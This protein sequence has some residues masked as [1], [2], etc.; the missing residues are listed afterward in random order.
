MLIVRIVGARPQFMQVPLLK[1]ALIEKGIQHHILHT[2]QHYDPALNEV[3]HSEL[4]LDDIR[5]N[6]NVGSGSHGQTTGKMIAGIEEFLLK[7]KPDAVLLDGDT[8]STLAGA[9]AA[10]KLQIPVIHVEAG[11]RDWDSSRPEEINRKLTDH[12]SRLN[13]APIPRALTNLQNEGLG[14]R[15]ELTG[16]LLLDCFLHY[17]A[18]A[19]FSILKKLNLSSGDYHI[20]TVHREENTIDEPN[21]RFYEI[22]RALTKLD[23]PVIF[24]VH[25]RTKPLFK[26]FV[27][28]TQDTHNIH[29]IEPVSYLEM[30]GL[31]QHCDC[32]LT[33]SGGLSR[34]AAW[35]G[36]RCVMLFLNVWHDLLES[37]SAQMADGDADSILESYYRARPAD[38][39]AIIQLFGNGQAAVLT[40]RKI[41][42]NFND[43]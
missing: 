31:L 25:P 11:V 37:E 28:N 42:E 6:L 38:D 39:K 36:K 8:N 16:D 27:E 26:E 29:A 12:I 32:V 24:P 18:L 4:G 20:A 19:D 1:N 17:K 10:S 41:Y 2:G 21:G 22:M 3:L 9:I 30:L 33:D 43:R 7:K 15:S 35:S 13:F 34:E 23:K 5:D 14:A 40:A